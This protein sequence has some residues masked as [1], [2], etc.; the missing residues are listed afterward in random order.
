MQPATTLS[1]IVPA[2]NEEPTLEIVVRKL[3]DLA[4]L[5]LE[6]IVVDDCSTDG[7]ADVALRLADTFP[8]VRV[9]R[10]TS[11]QGKTPALLKG[12][13]ASR[14]DI[15]MVQDADLEYDPAEIADLIAPIV[16]GVA[17]TVYGSRFAVKKAARALYFYHYVANKLITFLSNVLTNINLSDVAT[18]YKAFRGPIIRSMII[19]SRRFGFE[20]EVTAKLAKLKCAMY[21]VPIS[22][23]GRTYEQGKK[24][25]FMDA[26]ES[27]WYI[28][29]FNL[30][31][32]SG[33]PIAKYRH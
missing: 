29:R 28:L 2:F 24:I 19:E 22:Y 14:G 8:Q 9:I 6:V 31:A 26:L 11:N 20:F 12:I 33:P 23:Y 4:P 17:D 30:F 32:V 7:T 3:I 1:I 21:E 15:V 18:G 10:Q 27:F 25:V 13:A 16:S 5:L